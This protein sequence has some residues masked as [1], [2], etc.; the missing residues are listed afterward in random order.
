MVLWGAL[1]FWFDA[2][3]SRTVRDKPHPVGF[4]ANAKGFSVHVGTCSSE[5]RYSPRTSFEPAWSNLQT[6]AYSKAPPKTP[7]TSIGD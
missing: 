7:P 3:G 2:N 1:S 4:S 6:Y 5:V